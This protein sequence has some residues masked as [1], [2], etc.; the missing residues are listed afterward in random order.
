MQIA[1]VLWS[2]NLGGA[3]TFS[4]YLAAELRKRGVDAR[5]VF[6]RGG[7]PLVSRLSELS[8]PWAAL[9]F[10]R[11]RT[12]LRMPRAYARTVR[13]H[14]RNGAILM[15]GRYLATSLRLGGYKG[16]IV[17][18]EHGD[19]QEGRLRPPEGILD[20]GL[21]QLSRRLRTWDRTVSALAID[22]EVG[23]SDFMLG[24]MRGRPHAR[25]LRCIPY[26]IAVDRFR[27]S[28][29]LNESGPLRVGWAGR[30][31]AGKGSRSPIGSGPSLGGHDAH[32][33][34]TNRWGWANASR[35]D[36]T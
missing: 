22:V 29:P 27:P 5:I 11:G 25:D 23:V 8:V 3:E 16:R 6:V 12:V 13:N 26:G 35:A 2:G 4:S 1:F 20:R 19:M 30:M 21:V 28:R 33:A 34:Y 31:I 24:E 10:P 32:R 14:G 15:C 36:Q 17:A 18:V 7:D 9:N